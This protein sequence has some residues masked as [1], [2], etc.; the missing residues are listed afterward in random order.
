MSWK[1]AVKEF[2]GGDLAFLSVDGEVIR[3]IVVGEPVLLQGKYKGRPSEKIG[4]PVVTEDGFQLFII[5][6]RL[7][8]KLAKYEEQFGN[9]AFMAIRHG[10][11]GDIEST[12]ELKP[13]VEQDVIDRLLEIKATDF[14]PDMIG[15]AISAAQS[16]MS[17]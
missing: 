9:T 16:V 14:Q 12:Y 2:G 7:F 11:Q 3:F 4:A 5:G 17:T 6:K 1:E 10:E 15:E 8:R 13:L